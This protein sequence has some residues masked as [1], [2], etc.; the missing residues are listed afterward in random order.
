MPR[1]PAHWMGCIGGTNRGACS[2]PCCAAGRWPRR[3]GRFPLQLLPP[4]EPLQ[5]TKTT[6]TEHI[7]VGGLVTYTRALQASYS[8][9]CACV[10]PF[11]PAVAKSFSYNKTPR[12]SGASL[13]CV[14]RPSSGCDNGL[15]EGF[16]AFWS[17]AL[18]VKCSRSSM[19]MC[20]L[21]VTST[22]SQWFE[23]RL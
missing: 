21:S 5:L 9:E 15:D 18:G 2:G 11:S 14:L 23:I 10:R 12:V 20:G 13:V 17:R 6:P 3:T 16:Q 22:D 1:S 19:L 8:V 7:F 4:S